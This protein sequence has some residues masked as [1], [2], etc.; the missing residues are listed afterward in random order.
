M[1]VLLLCMHVFFYN[2]FVNSRLCFV[3]EKVASC[4]FFYACCAIRAEIVQIEETID[5]MRTCAYTRAEMYR[6]VCLPVYRECSV[7][8][9]FCVQI[10]SPPCMYIYTP[11][12]IYAYIYIY[13]Y[14]YMLGT[15]AACEGSNSNV[16][17]NHAAYA[18]MY[19]DT[20][21]HTPRLDAMKICEGFNRM[22]VP[23]TLHM[24]ICV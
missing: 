4:V 15:I 20:F 7:F 24:H 16:C 13:I 18:H 1:Y 23:T 21:I 17:H 5:E 2:F 12:Y 19:I 3:N 22:G 9:R 11:T 10:V 6:Q 8:Q 14:I